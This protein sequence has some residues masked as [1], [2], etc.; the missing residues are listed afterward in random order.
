MHFGLTAAEKE[1]GRSKVCDG[2][3]FST[4][5]WAG[6]KNTIRVSL[7]EDPWYEIDPCKRLIRYAEHYLGQGVAP[8]EEKFRS[9]ERDQKKK[10]LLCKKSL[11][12]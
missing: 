9:I 5:R 11:L 2:N 10:R 3:W 12:P 4:S 6:R 1:N 8:F 7:T